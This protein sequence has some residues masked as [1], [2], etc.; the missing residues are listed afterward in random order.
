MDVAIDK[1]LFAQ[2]GVSCHPCPANCSFCSF[3]KDY[4]QMQPFTM[5]DEDIVAAVKSFTQDGDLFG[6]WIMSMADYDID[7]YC[8]IVRL[9]RETAPAC[10]NLYSNVGDSS[11]EDFLKMKEAGI[12]GGAVIGGT[13]LIPDHVANA[14]FQIS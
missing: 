13:G 3:A 12:S 11:L 8:R 7:E 1:M 5:A 9:V 6:L 4:T 10:T 14:I 2:I